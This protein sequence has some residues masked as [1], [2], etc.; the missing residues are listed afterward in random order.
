MKP[1]DLTKLLRPYKSG[2]V[3]LSKDYKKVITF[4]PTLEK[5]D[6][7]LD[8]LENPDVVLISASNNYR[9]FVT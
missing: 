3:A 7:K 4:A 6:S 9:G 1:V 2:W 8:K 5:L